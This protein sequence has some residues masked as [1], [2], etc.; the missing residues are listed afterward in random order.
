MNQLLGVISTTLLVGKPRLT[1]HQLT[2]LSNSTHM[3][4]PRRTRR[5]TNSTH[6]FVFSQWE[7]QACGIRVQVISCSSTCDRETLSGSLV[8]C[9]NQTDFVSLWLSEGIGEAQQSVPACCWVFRPWPVCPGLSV[10]DDIEQPGI[11]ALVGIFGQ[12]KPCH[13]SSLWTPLVA[14]QWWETHAELALW[15]I[16]F[17]PI[18]NNTVAINRSKS[19]VLRGGI[20]MW[21]RLHMP[22]L[23]QTLWRG[24]RLLYCF[25]CD[26][27][28]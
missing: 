5:R 21:W 17:R 8:A 7:G 10:Q 28:G 27:D 3:G 25:S 6:I 22:A 24:K 11:V 20:L 18:F 9:Y 12:C 26:E 19:K 2:Y 16:I 14:G 15:T 4:S 1:Y 23:L 13:I